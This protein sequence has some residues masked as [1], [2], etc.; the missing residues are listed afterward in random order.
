MKYHNRERLW[1]ASD[2]AFQMHPGLPVFR[3]TPKYGGMAVYC[4]AVFFDM[5]GTLVDGRDGILS[6]TPRTRQAIARLRQNGY[7]AGLATGRAKCYLPP[8]ADLFDCLVTSNG[9]Y[10]E[11][12]GRTACDCSV[13]PQVLRAY[14]ERSGINYLLE[15]QEGC[16]VHDI[17][18]Y[19][20]NQMMERFHWDR[21][22]FFP[23]TEDS[24]LRANK[25]MV[26]YDSMDKLYRF[27]RD[28]GDRFDITEQP[29]NQSADVGIRG[30][31]KGYG[32]GRVMELLGIPRE[33]TWAF[34]DADNDLEM[35]KTVGCGVAMGRHTE[36]VG[37]AARFVTGTV[38]EDGVAA[39]LEKLGLI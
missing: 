33:S 10:A 8:E 19:W 28:F 38:R 27:Q 4:G 31:S 13:D 15:C 11:A 18:E 25:L 2:F 16:Y 9:A 3:R 20:Y 30:I 35:L 22:R 26:M 7:L 24:P 6:V 17:H 29:V 37:K 36:A 39:A 32:V 14:L 21:S 5:D 23:L 34:G 12:D 1:D